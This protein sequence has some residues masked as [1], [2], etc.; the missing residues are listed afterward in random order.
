MLAAASAH[1]DNITKRGS[2]FFAVSPAEPSAKRFRGDGTRILRIPA[3]VRDTVVVESVP[4]SAWYESDVNGWLYKYDTGQ[5]EQFVPSF[6]GYPIWTKGGLYTVAARWGFAVIPPEI[7]SA[8]A[9]I[10]LNWWRAG[11]GTLATVNPNGFI[12]ERDVPPSA[13]GI[14]DAWTK[15]EFDL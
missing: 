7:S 1:I 3:H 8:V 5:V 4:L 14:V 2:G 10:T 9:Q 12:I 13:Q 6:D 15:G 11:N